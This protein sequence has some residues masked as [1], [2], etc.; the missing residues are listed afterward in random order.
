MRRPVET[1]LA[2]A[3]AI[4]GGVAKIVGEP[5]GVD[6][7][8]LGHAAADDAGAA[9]A[10]FLGDHR[11]R[12]VAGGDPR[13]AHAARSR[14]DDE[15]INVEAHDALSARGDQPLCKKSLTRRNLQIARNPAVTAIGAGLQKS[16]PFFFISSRARVKHLGRKSAAARLGRAP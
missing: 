9:D 15:Q 11:A 6:Q 5:A 14:A 10:E 13:R 7:Q 3:P 1:R 8:F 4:A 2:D 12:A 16:T